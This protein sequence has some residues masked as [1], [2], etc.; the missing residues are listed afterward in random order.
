MNAGDPNPLPIDLRPLDRRDTD[1]SLR[2]ERMATDELLEQPGDES[3]AVKAVRERRS[4]AEDQLRHVRANVDARLD[5]QASVLPEVSDKLEQVAGNLSQAAASLTGVAESLKA[6][7]GHARSGAATDVVDGI[8]ELS[9]A[10]KDTAEAAE[11]HRAARPDPGASAVVARQLAEVA[12]GIAQVTSTLAEERRDVDD[13]V[14]DERLITDRV[15]KQELD[16]VETAVAQQLEEEHLALRAEREATD[17]D[18]AKERRHTDEAVEHVAGL[19]AEERRDHAHAAQSFSTRNEFLSIVSHDL[20]G[21]LMTISGLASMIDQHAGVDDSGRRIRTWADRVQ[22]SVNV[23]ERLIGDLLDFGSFEDG[24][25]RVA[26]EQLDIRTLLRGAIEAFHAVAE[27]KRLTLAA[28]VPEQPVMAKYDPNRMFQ[29]LSNLIH[30]AIKFTP[31]GGSIRL[32][33]AA[34]AAGCEVSVS[35]TGIGIPE[36]DLTSIFERFRQ[37]DRADRTGLGLG[38]YISSWIVEA[39]GGRIWA[40]SRLGSGT[41]F[42]LTLP[43]E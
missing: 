1:E 26:A 24:Q 33:A 4:E 30:N 23:M 14:R 29:V 15:I 19:L 37:L 32:R 10:L 22:R 31:E 5:R 27:G 39:H 43:G 28:E 11:P 20:R 7:S 9:R 40:E 12:E 16:Q 21:P 25:L 8:A 6:P 17:E 38:L 41:T 35:D 13:H 3:T 18:L 2:E 36:G 34:T 42:H